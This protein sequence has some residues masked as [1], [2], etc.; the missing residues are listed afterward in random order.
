MPSSDSKPAIA[1]LSLR[2]VTRK[3]AG[4]PLTSSQ[5]LIHTSS[6]LSPPQREKSRP[7]LDVYDR[8]SVLR[9][10]A[11]LHDAAEGV[12]QHLHTVA[13]SEHGDAGLYELDRHCGRVVVKH[14]ARA[15]GE[16]DS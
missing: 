5:W 11:A 9:R 10:F 13:Y 14:A 8:A 16:D 12:G 6:F 4:S 2:A 7:P 3:P 15:A 1:P